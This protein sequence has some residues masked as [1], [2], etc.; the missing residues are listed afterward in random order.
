VRPV[1]ADGARIARQLL[2]A[3]E[4]GFR[5]CAQHI[6]DAHDHATGSQQA[7]EYAERRGEAR[8]LLAAVVR[9]D[10]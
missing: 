9:S 8:A 2:I 5:A 7:E 3:G 10:G 1:A 4:E 6:G